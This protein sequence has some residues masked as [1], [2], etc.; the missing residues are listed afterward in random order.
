MTEGLKRTKRSFFN[1][2]VTLSTNVI[3]L[4]TAFLVQKVL[5]SSLG[6]DYNG[7]NGLFTN[8]ITM[9]SLTDLG[10]GSAIIYHLY[11]PT[12]ESDYK[13]ICS[14]MRFYKSSY[15]V[16]SGVVFIIGII[17]MFFLPQLVGTTTVRENLYIIFFLFMADCLVSYFLSYKKS[18]LYAYQMNYVLDGIHFGYYMLQNAAQLFVLLYFKS[19]IIFLLLK[20]ISKYIE[21]VT[22]SVYIQKRYSFVR[23]KNV[24]PLARDIRDDIIVKVKALLFHRLGKLFVTGSDSL[25][26]TS[27]LGITQM[28]LYTNYSLILGGITALLNKVFETLT[29]SVGNFLLESGKEQR[30]C[31]YRKIDFLNFWFFGCATVVLYALFQPVII[32]WVGKEYLFSQVVFFILMLKF[33]QEGM[34]ASVLT[35]KDAAGIYYEDRF[36]PLAEAA[37]NVFL[38]IIL[39]RKVGIAGVF[40][41]TVISAG[42]IYF[43]SF[44]KYVCFPLFQMRWMEYIGL[45]V[46]HFSIVIAAMFLTDFLIMRFDSE[47]MFFKIIISAGIAFFVFH[48]FLFI[49]YRRSNEIKYFKKILINYILKKEDSQK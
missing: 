18:L 15:M 10:I 30:Y 28:S 38:S 37:L 39:A 13:T 20:T 35:F 42:I 26:I 23:E 6:S 31:I 2:I 5:I 16:I 21:N 46:R 22:I 4:A 14:L 7:V 47:N 25:V 40:L 17:V 36:I 3:I 12:A 48:S 41:G 24:L 44:P 1:V 27:I 29:S 32:L 8:I 11:R 45:T 33:Y 34:R 9:M 19:Y 43:Y 49:F